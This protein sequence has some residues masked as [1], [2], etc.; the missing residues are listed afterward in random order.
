MNWRSLHQNLIKLTEMKIDRI[1]AT[2]IGWFHLHG[3]LRF[4]IH[5]LSLSIPPLDGIIHI[6]TRLGFIAGA[7]L[8]WENMSAKQTFYWELL[9]SFWEPAE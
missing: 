2:I 7:W 4:F 3:V 9:T 5:Y 8:L 6:I 1:W